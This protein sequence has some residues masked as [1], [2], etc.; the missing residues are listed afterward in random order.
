MTAS[1]QHLAIDGS[2]VTLTSGADLTAPATS[3]GRYTIDGIV[4]EI[5]TQPGVFFDVLVAAEGVRPTEEYQYRDGTLRIG[6]T[7]HPDPTTGIERLDNTAVWESAGV[8]LAITTIDLS[9]EAL[10]GV[11]DRFDLTPGTGGLAVTPRAG[12]AWYD[13]PGLV[14]ELPGI[15][16]CEVFPLSNDIAGGLPSWPGTAVAGGDLYQDEMAPGAPYVVLITE[17]ARV[18]VLPDTGAIEAAV[19][20]ASTLRVDWARP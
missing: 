12:P 17:T 19:E 13:A 9:T 15:G 4:R 2:T 3:I 5:T 8:S 14:K 11:L 7:T 20:G 6:Q 10:L 1:V 16:L 18:N